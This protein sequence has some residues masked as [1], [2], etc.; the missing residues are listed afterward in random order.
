MSDKASAIRW[1]D[2]NAPLSAVDA[3]LRENGQCP[4]CDG[5]GKVDPVA[6]ID[7]LGK[8]TVMCSCDCGECSHERKCCDGTGKIDKCAS[9]NGTGKPKIR[10]RR[11][12]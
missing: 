7:C 12:A 2:P 4:E 5:A 6:C 11:A 3:F 8:G 1:P 10:G 9:C